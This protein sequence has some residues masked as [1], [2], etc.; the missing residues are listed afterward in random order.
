MCLFDILK[1]LSTNNS[2]FLKKKLYSHSSY[3]SKNNLT[4]YRNNQR[5]F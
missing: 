5:W 2:K 1:Y 3:F 4:K